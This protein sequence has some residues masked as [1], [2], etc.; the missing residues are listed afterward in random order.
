MLILN[1]ILLG[2]DVQEFRQSGVSGKTHKHATLAAEESDGT[3][4]Q[5]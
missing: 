1:V 4:S 5:E 2:E 3:L